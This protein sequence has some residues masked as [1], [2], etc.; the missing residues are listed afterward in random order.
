MVIY[1]L[2]ALYVTKDLNELLTGDYQLEIPETLILL[3]M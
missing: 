1:C 3:N 2:K